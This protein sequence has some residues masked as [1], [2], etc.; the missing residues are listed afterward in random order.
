MPPRLVDPGGPKLVDVAHSDRPPVGDPTF[1]RVVCEVRD[2]VYWTGETQRPVARSQ[3]SA[4]AASTVG[5]AN[6]LVASPCAG[7][8]ESGFGVVGS[9]STDSNAALYPGSHDEPDEDEPEIPQL[10]NARHDPPPTADGAA[11]DIMSDDGCEAPPSAREQ[12]R[13][14]AAAFGGWRYLLVGCLVAAGCGVVAGVAL[15]SNVSETMKT[16]VMPGLIV[17]AVSAAGMLFAA[18]TLDVAGALSAVLVGYRRAS[19]V[20]FLNGVTAFL[21]LL[22]NAAQIPVVSAAAGATAVALTVLAGGGVLSTAVAIAAAVRLGAVA[23]AL[24]ESP[25]DVAS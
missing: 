9:A 10:V 4:P 22:A 14:V 3:S 18:A 12:C 17:V 20:V 7:A 16:W 15:D 25:Q 24:R 23:K 2:P 11:G 1:M 13:H 8:Y 5:I 6:M 19:F 21:L